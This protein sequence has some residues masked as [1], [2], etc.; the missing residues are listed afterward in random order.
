MKKLCML[1]L[2]MVLAGFIST[3]TVEAST[4]SDKGVTTQAK[5]KAKKKKKVKKSKKKNKE[6]FKQEEEKEDVLFDNE[7]IKF[8]YL[9][10][11]KKYNALY[12]M[13]FKIENK[14]DKEIMVDARDSSVDNEMAYIL[15]A[16]SSIMPGKNAVQKWMFNETTLVLPK[17]NV[18][19]KIVVSDEEFNTLLET[20]VIRI[21]MKK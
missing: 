2:V 14:T 15:G 12:Y 19:F 9:G 21:D 8:T 6:A 11:T 17:D 18:E 3:S 4:L 1:L 13:N 10:I 7:M 5:K 16:H 20:E